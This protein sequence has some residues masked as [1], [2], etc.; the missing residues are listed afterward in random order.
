MEHTFL[1]PLCL[2]SS[3]DARLTFRFNTFFLM[4]IP[5]RSSPLMLLAPLPRIQLF[6]LYLAVPAYD[7]SLSPF[8]SG[9]Q[10]NTIPLSSGISIQQNQQKTFLYT[11]IFDNKK[12][13]MSF[14]L[15]TRYLIFPLYNS[16]F[17]FL[18][19]KDFTKKSRQCSFELTVCLIRYQ[20]SN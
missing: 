5:R 18:Y 2:T 9:F 20:N 13:I 16:I 11:G 4:E 3:L 6:L 17:S 10:H 1:Y 12:L 8:C 15:T 7:I 14:F 19:T